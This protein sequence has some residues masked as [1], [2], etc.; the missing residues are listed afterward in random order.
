M[1]HPNLDLYSRYQP[2]RHIVEPTCWILFFC[3]QA[4]S[5]S[6][7]SWLDQ[8]RFESHAEWWEPVVWEWS[9]C[10]VL[11]AL[12][13]IVILVEKRFPLRWATL[14]PNLLWHLLASIPFSLLHVAAMVG[15]R[16]L[17]YFSQHREYEFSDWL[18][19][20]GYEYLK[21]IHTYFFIVIAV[22]S[23]RLLILRWQGEASL[24][25]EPDIGKPVEPIE[26]PERF[27]VRTLGKEFLLP[28]AEIEWMQAWG[29][30]VNLHVRGHDYPL[31]STM[32][33]IE[34]RVDP[35]RFVRIH[36]SYIANVD[37]IKEIEPQ[38]SGDAKA[39]MRD[40]HQIAVSRKY[41]DQLKK[42]MRSAS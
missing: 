28:A 38:E 25:Q 16:K 24:L 9:S 17:F 5:N 36:R 33:G 13:P 11:L 32:A 35:K 20:S 12:V 18:H 27:L 4:I 2:Y 8:L 42:V 37:F 15:I 34:Q 1:S 3:I 14:R 31:R 23:Y 29:N 39:V 19:E 30:Y 22:A 21:D 41:R 40:G 26:R 7:I 6:R 10:M